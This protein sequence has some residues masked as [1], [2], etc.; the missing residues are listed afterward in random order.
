MHVSD[1]TIGT[2]HHVKE[3]DLA[4]DYSMLDYCYGHIPQIFSDHKDSIPSVVD[5]IAL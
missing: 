5:I 3:T 4:C 2:S 1:V